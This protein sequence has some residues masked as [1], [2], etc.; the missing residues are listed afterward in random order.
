VT[1]TTIS[2]AS[3]ALATHTPLVFVALW[4]VMTTL[5]SSAQRGSVIGS[6]VQVSMPA[7]AI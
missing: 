5:S 3:A 2:A 1:L 4:D 7:P 6:V